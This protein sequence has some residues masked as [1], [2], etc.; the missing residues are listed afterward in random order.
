MRPL[1]TFGQQ[2]VFTTSAIVYPDCSI[3]A[4][5]PSLPSA[6][7]RDRGHSAPSSRVT[8]K[9]PSTPGAT[10][11]YERG[12]APVHG[13]RA[14]GP[15]TVRQ[16]RGRRGRPPCLPCW[17]APVPARIAGPR[18][19]PV[20]RPPCLPKTKKY[21]QRLIQHNNLG[22]PWCALGVLVVNLTDWRPRLLVEPFPLSR[23]GDGEGAERASM[24]S[25]APAGMSGPITRC[26]TLPEGTRPWGRNFLRRGS[27]RPARRPCMHGRRRS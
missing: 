13:A 19:C 16:A 24:A 26:P 21:P 10:K 1:T 3:L 8:T 2:S 6:S 4:R 18:A 27:A 22:G 9:A 5:P 20:G 7:T 17:Q 25:T 15:H 11:N 23:R 12:F 14:G